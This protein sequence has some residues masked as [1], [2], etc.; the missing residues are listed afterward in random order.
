MAAED[1]GIRLVHIFE[2]EWYFKQEIVKSMISNILGKTKRKIY[3]RKC[4]I[5]EVGRFEKKLFLDKNHIQGD[6]VTNINIGLYYEGELV[7][8]MCFGKRRVN[9]GKKTTNEGEYELLRFCNLLNTSV[10]G[11]AS[12]LFKYFIDICGE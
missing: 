8:L 10:I 5:K 2:D 1:A 4:K 7:S 12:K 3:A 11:G 9:L 6:V